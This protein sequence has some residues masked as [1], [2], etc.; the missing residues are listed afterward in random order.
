MGINNSLIKLGPDIQK[1]SFFVRWKVAIGGLSAHSGLSELY[2]L[3]PSKASFVSLA[4]P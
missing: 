1:V 2:S 4:F 3:L